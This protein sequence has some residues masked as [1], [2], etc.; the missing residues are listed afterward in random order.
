MNK[1][2]I[3]VVIPIYNVEKYVDKCLTS[4]EKQTYS[5]FNVLAIDDGSSDN[6][7]D[8]VKKHALK[9]NRITLIEKKNGGYGSVLQLALKNINT[10]YFLICDPDD[11]LAPNALKI[12]H[13][14]AEK[15][16]PDII[17]ADKYNVYVGEE[18]HPKYVSSVPEWLNIKTNYIYKNDEMIQKFSFLSV[19]P[20]SKLYKT[21][22]TR[23]IKFP[24]KVSFTDF[25]LYILALANT[26]RVMYYDKALAY[27]LI[28]RPGNT[29]TDVNPK[30][31]S[32][33]CTVW[34]S[35]YKQLK[36]YSTN[37]IDILWW[38]MYADLQ[39][40]LNMCSKNGLKKSAFIKV[41]PLAMM[42]KKYKKNIKR[43][44]P[45]NIKFRFMLNGLLNKNL[46]IIFAKLYVAIKN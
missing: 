19:S 46:F 18:S 32:Y 12:L 43:V 23:S 14:L 21:E 11:W 27:Y 4:I 25:E 31:V 37:N 36:K 42:L 5:N 3:T 22:I 8:I 6:S 35:T 1:E 16:H 44:A 26:K 28:N 7:K 2:D 30:I 29:T 20:H 13:E 24:T 9:D 40:I 34:E 39:N 41:Y 15:N 17:V 45:K 38:R 10:K 33:Y